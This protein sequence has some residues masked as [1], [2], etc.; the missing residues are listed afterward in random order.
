MNNKF[1][2]D[3]SFKPEADPLFA[4]EVKA[5]SDTFRSKHRADI[6]QIA[7]HVLLSTQLMLSFGK[8]NDIDMKVHLAIQNVLVS[9][10]LASAEIEPQTFHAALADL[11][12]AS[13]TASILSSLPD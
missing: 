5:L 11:D 10:W 1:T 3:K 12:M 8:T 9:N 7:S 13:Q 2:T 4:S 6:A